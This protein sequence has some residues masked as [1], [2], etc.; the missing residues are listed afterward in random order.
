VTGTAPNC[1]CLCRIELFG[2][3]SDHDALRSKS[4][5]PVGSLFTL[6]SLKKIQTV[7]A[8]VLLLDDLEGAKAPNPFLATSAK[9][10]L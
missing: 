6:S 4:S 5:L 10:L 3:F 8:D 7:V 1:G 9:A 2:E